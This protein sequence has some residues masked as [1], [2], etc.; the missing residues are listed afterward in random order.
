MCVSGD[1]VVNIPPDFDLFSRALHTINALGFYRK[2]IERWTPDKKRIG[3]ET[4][5][6]CSRHYHRIEDKDP[7]DPSNS[8]YFWVCCAEQDVI[9][10]KAM[11]IGKFVTSVREN[12]V[13]TKSYA[14]YLM[15]N[16]FHRRDIRM[17]CLAA[18]S[19]IDVTWKPV[20]DKAIAWLGKEIPWLSTDHILDIMNRVLITENPYLPNKRTWTTFSEIPYLSKRVDNGCGSRCEYSWRRSW[21]DA[22][23][24]RVL[25]LRSFYEG[26]HYENYLGCITY[27]K[28]VNL[29]KPFQARVP[30]LFM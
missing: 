4:V 3:L 26:E 9:I 12:M 13:W 2:D 29:G 30:E 18:L 7:K 23:P 25:S 17:G 21:K 14:I 28:D 11:N 20:D 22:L 6:F 24:R 16:F 5:E 27:F 10:A 15:L 8:R 1:D 19:A